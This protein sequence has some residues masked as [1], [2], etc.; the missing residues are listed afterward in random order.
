M[1]NQTKDKAS[2]DYLTFERN[3]RSFPPEELLK[4][5]GLTYAWSAD[6]LHILASGNDELEVAEKLKEL[7]IG[8][9]QVVFDNLPDCDS[10]F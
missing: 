2:F 3:S 1:A 5:R 9:D 7:G 6:G 4:Y 10:I 8:I